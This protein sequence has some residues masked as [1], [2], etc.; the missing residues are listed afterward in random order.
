MRL[1]VLG[2]DVNES[3]YKFSVNQAGAV[4][5][6]MGAIKGVGHGA[7]KTIV[8]NRKK[9]GHYKSIFDLAKRI[10][11]RAANK[12]AFENLVL[13][14]GFDSFDN[15]RAQYMQD[16]GDGITFYE[17]VLKYA[18]RYQETQNSS[19]VSLFGDASEVQIPE[20]EVPFCEEWGT[21]KK[22]KQ[23]KEVVGVYIS[24]HPLDD[25]KTEMKSFTNCK[26]SDFNELEK[27]VNREL[28]FGG[29]VSDV[30]HRESKAGK[31][32]A[33]FTV[34]DYED[35]YDFKIFGEEYLKWRH[36]LVPN[37][38][39]YG[40]VYVKEGWTNRE[41]GKKGEPRLQYNS[42]QML[43]DVMDTQARKLTIQMPIEE[44]EAGKID[45]LKDL[46]T[47]HKGDKHLHFTIY[48]VEN[49]VKLSMPSR[50]HKVTIS[51]E[52]LLELEK[53]QVKY[54]LN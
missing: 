27:F 9:D 8:E 32:W 44:L 6:G 33:I 21:M 11:L 29:V 28:C 41:T 10:E 48:E 54:R 23:E 37:S 25:F 18:S 15:H 53:E 12:K 17:K 50:K 36:F 14:G 46:F 13:A 7:V 49:K 47:L 19:Q 5:F 42:M 1:D 30:Q 38:F 43:H 45:I 4:R 31:G 20:P 52:L 39:I 22:L 34:E 16:E 26:V 51:N 3:Y 35:S 2:P 40:R 24:G